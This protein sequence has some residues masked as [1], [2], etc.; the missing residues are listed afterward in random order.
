[1][2][3]QTYCLVLTFLVCAFAAWTNWSSQRAWQARIAAV[4]EHAAK[5]WAQLEVENNNLR[6]ANSELHRTLLVAARAPQAAPPQVVNGT[7]PRRAPLP[8]REHPAS[9]EVFGT[10]EN[11]EG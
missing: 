11:L 9:R 4:Q 2:T 8:V 5:S 7:V 10:P 3:P 6:K 1:M